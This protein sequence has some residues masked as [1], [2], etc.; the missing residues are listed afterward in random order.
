[1]VWLL[2]R[3]RATQKAAMTLEVILCQRLCKGIGNLFFRVD[4]KNLDESLPNML[5]KVMVAYV[6]G[7][8]D[9]GH[10]IGPLE[11]P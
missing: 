3:L 11:F 10:E 8:P 5:T 9:V 6:A 1:M 4:G 2:H 7:V